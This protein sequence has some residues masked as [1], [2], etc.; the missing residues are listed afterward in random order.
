MYVLATSKLTQLHFK[1]NL[2]KIEYSNILGTYI[3][4]MSNKV[5]GPEYWIA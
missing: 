4:Y 3:G 2:P 5:S 1:S